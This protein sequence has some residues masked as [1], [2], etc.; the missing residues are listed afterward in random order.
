MTKRILLVEDHKI[1]RDGLKFYF[2]DTDEYEIVA[3]AENGEEGLNILKDD[4]FD[5]VITDISMPKMDGIQF[6]KE[7]HEKYPNQKVIA[8]TMMGESQHIKQMIAYGV[9]GYLLKNSGE[10]EI[11][12]A[13]EVVFAG[14][15]FFSK[16]V[17]NAII[18]DLQGKR[19]P[20]QRLTVE[21]PLSDRE[22]EV[23]RLIAEEYS[24]KEI[25]DKLFIS[26]RTVDAHKRNMLEKTG[27]K[28]IAG[29]IM[30]AIEHEIV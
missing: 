12:K 29:L 15:T 4:V 10:E 6:M 21:T 30:Y 13:I 17:T 1:V 22:K 19:K 26:V 27:A 24:N 5:L 18:N 3:E 9:N 14:E 11:F 2:E 16:E 28:N 7:V 23:L 8:L 25:A 20:K